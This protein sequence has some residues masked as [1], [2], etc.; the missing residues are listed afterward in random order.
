M[1]RLE[2]GPFWFVLERTLRGRGRIL[3]GRGLRASLRLPAWSGALAVAAFLAASNAPAAEK[4]WAGISEGGFVTALAVDPA[5]PSRVYAATARGLFSSSDDGETWSPLS[6]GLAGQFV[7][8]LAVR[9]GGSGELYAGTNS[10]AVLRTGDGKAWAR[11]DSGLGDSF[12]AALLLDPA[13]PATLYAG[14][15]HGVFKSTDGG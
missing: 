7:G 13:S 8:A 1:E 5:A 12:V 4:K 14:T 9:P 11:L 3:D 2:R 6:H 10:G 15:N